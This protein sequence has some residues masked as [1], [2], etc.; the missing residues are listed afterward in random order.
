ME[1][2]ESLTVTQADY[3]AGFKVIA[4]AF[5]DATLADVINQDCTILFTVDTDSATIS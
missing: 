2:T 5:N 1:I 3:D 4:R